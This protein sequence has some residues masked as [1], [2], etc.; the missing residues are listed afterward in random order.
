MADD[1]G[2][3]SSAPLC[4]NQLKGLDDNSTV[5]PLITVGTE[6]VSTSWLKGIASFGWQDLMKL[7]DHRKLDR[8]ILFG[9][10]MEASLILEYPDCFGSDRLAGLV[11]DDQ[12]SG[13]SPTPP[14]LPL[15]VLTERHSHA[16]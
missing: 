4:R 13:I 5:M 15:P 1:A 6:S 8:I 9:H 7:I 14:V 2:M 16:A 3:P 11:I 10:S 12:P